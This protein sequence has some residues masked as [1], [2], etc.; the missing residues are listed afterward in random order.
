[1]ATPLG[2]GRGGP[3]SSLWLCQRCSLERKSDQAAPVYRA[4]ALLREHL[5]QL[6]GELDALLHPEV[7]PRPP[8]RQRARLL[9]LAAQLSQF[10]LSD[11]Q[12][13]LPQ[14]LQRCEL[15]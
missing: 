10:T 6:L 8:L 1:M 12:A 5:T 3:V 2:F 4:L 13:T 7:E 15:S 9:A 14:L 11:L